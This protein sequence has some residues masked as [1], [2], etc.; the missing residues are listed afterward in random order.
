MLI[1]GYKKFGLN[2]REI[3]EYMGTRTSV[4]VLHHYKQ[5][6]NYTATKNYF[7]KKSSVSGFWTLEE[8]KKLKEAIEL[9]G[10]YALV[11]IALHV[12]TR[13]EG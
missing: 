4:Q 6:K 7:N 11:E 3:S 8:R 12:G 13:S 9:F 10:K 5:L 1:E 2:F